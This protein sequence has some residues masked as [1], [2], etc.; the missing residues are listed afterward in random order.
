MSTDLV[1]QTESK[2]GWQ[3]LARMPQ[4]DFDQHLVEIRV[5]RDR[6]R[7]IQSAVMEDGVHFG[8]VAGIDKPFLHQPGAEVL[9]QPLHLVPEYIGTPLFG[10][11]ITT[12]LISVVSECRLHLGDLEGPVVG[13]GRGAC[14]SWEKK[15]RYRM[16]DRSCPAC[17]KSGTVIKGKAEY[18]GG[19]LCWAKKGGCNAKFPEGS[20]EIEKQVAGTIENPDQFDLLNTY[21]SMADKRAYVKATRTTTA[22]SDLFTQDEDQVDVPHKDDAPTKTATPPA[23][24]T[25][26]PKKEEPQNADRLITKAEQ[27]AL[28]AKLKSLT[29]DPEASNEEVK[30]FAVLLCDYLGVQATKDIPHSVY[31]QALHAA[32]TPKMPYQERISLE[33]WETL[34]Q[35]INAKSVDKAKFLASYAVKYPSDLPEM[36]FEDAVK[37]AQ[38][39]PEEML[40]PDPTA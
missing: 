14:T 8:K 35:F 1:V 28:I 3:Q 32:T 17:G 9:C 12:P 27:A 25:P 21:V 18:G 4:Q 2:S 10:D 36:H 13:T 40:L 24:A 33:Q 22:T 31:G 29:G 34:V 30:P 16:A 37:K 15:Y 23:K 6:V 39:P 19:W 38:N 26:P 7:A 20:P 5:A 11:G